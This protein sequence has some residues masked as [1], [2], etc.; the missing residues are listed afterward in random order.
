MYTIQI[1]GKCHKKL[2][3]NQFKEP[4][5]YNRLSLKWNGLLHLFTTH[6]Q[7]KDGIIMNL[8]I[9]LRFCL[10]RDM[11]C[12]AGLECRGKD[13]PGRSLMFKVHQKRTRQGGELWSSPRSV[14]SFLPVMASFSS[15][16]GRI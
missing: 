4:L 16:G 10:I 8:S 14:Y 7:V 13:A 9:K 5:K 1:L 12:P 3:T 6:C 2:L 15:D 11:E